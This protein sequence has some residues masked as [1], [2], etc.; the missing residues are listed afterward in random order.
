M[1]EWDALAAGKVQWEKSRWNSI[2]CSRQRI[3]L[4]LAPDDAWH[5]GS[6]GMSS[7]ALFPNMD[8]VGLRMKEKKRLEKTLRLAIA[9]IRNDANSP[10]WDH[11]PK[12]REQR[13]KWC[14]E[15]L[16][17][18]GIEEFPPAKRRKKK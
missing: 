15:L 14:D 9:I 5:V 3:E 17:E 7:L 18:S 4:A 2:H 16:A 10:I 8:H 12:T 6:L 11:A 1:G 13:N